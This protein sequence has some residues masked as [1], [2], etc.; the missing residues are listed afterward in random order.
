MYWGSSCMEKNFPDVLSIF[1]Q[2][3]Y[4]KVCSHHHNNRDL[5]HLQYYIS[6]Q[7]VSDLFG[8]GNSTTLGL[9]LVEFCL[10]SPT[11][12]SVEEYLL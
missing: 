7:R 5:Q 10:I 9:C 11:S 12:A 8:Y 4:S 3:Y 2:H 1:Y 6:L